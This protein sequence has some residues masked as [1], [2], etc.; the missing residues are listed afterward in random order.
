MVGA[1]DAVK[2][3]PL[4]HIV[5]LDHWSEDGWMGVEDACNKPIHSDIHSIGWLLKEDEHRYLI[6]NNIADDG[7]G[8]MYMC[9]LKGTVTK[10]EVLANGKEIT[11][12]AKR[13]AVPSPK[14]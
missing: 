6:C 9:I 5:W 14:R 13:K 12:D 11:I 1:F 7:T 8:C 2:H 4:V 3:Y 10:F